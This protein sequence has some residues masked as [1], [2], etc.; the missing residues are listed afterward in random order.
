M[1]TK[2]N[3]KL[4]EEIDFRANVA[5]YHIQDLLDDLSNGGSFSFE[6]NE[7]YFKKLFADFVAV[8]NSK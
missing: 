2:F 7:A 6:K 4:K 8:V 1:K 5:T 3:K